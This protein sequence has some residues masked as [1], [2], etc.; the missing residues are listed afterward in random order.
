MRF[1]VL[2]LGSIGTLISYHLRRSI[3]LRQQ[4][5]FLHTPGIDPIPPEITAGLP[6]NAADTSVTLHL[7]REY[8][9]QAF[10]G[11]SVEH[12]GIHRPDNAIPQGPSI[13]EQAGYAK[14]PDAIDSL[15]VTTKA[16][17]TVQAIAPLSKRLTPAS[18]VVLLQNGMGVVDELIHTVFPDTASR[19]QIILG[20]LSHG[21]YS[22]GQFQTIHAG[23]GSM[24]LGLIPDPRGRA[25]YERR[26]QG[27]AT[28]SLRVPDS[29]TT[30]RS[31]LSGLDLN[32]IPRDASHLTLRYTLASLLS[33]PLDV[34]WDPLE[35]YQVGALRKLVVNACIN[36]LTAIMD[37]QNGQLV[38]DPYAQQIW[39]EVCHEAAEV[40]LAAAQADMDGPSSARRMPEYSAKP[41]LDPSLT[42]S[43]LFSAVR[44]V[45]TKTR[46]NYSSMHSDVRGRGRTEIDY[47]NGYLVQLGKAF[48]VEVKT[49][50]ML[51]RLVLSL[52]WGDKK[53]TWQRRSQVREEEEQQER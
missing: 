26:L 29:D 32:A 45:A 49:N 1:H 8:V 18:T 50:E 40:F 28:S 34:H 5:G 12:A 39:S 25:E 44:D 15:I 46:K 52:G 10:S 24:R 7:R 36:P 17:A 51:R 27:R 38:G 30:S 37:C 3:R 21:C 6:A 11:A 4:R 42:P 31:N 22:R 20:N 9:A 47:M 14:G 35:S 33:L 16:D 43:A 41:L 23:Y 2:G 53:A 19:P 13:V 48:G